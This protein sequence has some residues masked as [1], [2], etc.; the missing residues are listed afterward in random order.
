MKLNFFNKVIDNNPFLVY[1]MY[2]EIYY[3]IKYLIYNLLY[4]KDGQATL[5][6]D[7]SNKLTKFQKQIKN[8]MILMKV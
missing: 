6:E 3:G 7:E 2:K 4:L 8:M 1:I 5:N